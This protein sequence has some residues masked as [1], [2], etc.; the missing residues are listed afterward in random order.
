[1]KN[2][3]QLIRAEGHHVRQRIC[4]TK[5]QTLTT[6]AGSGLGLAAIILARSK[7]CLGPG[8]TASCEYRA[9]RVPA[10]RLVTTPSK[11]K[12]EVDF[13][14]RQFLDMLWPE[15]WYLLGAVV[16]AFGV[17]LVN[18]QIPLLLGDVVNVVSSLT[19]SVAQ[20]DFMQQIREPAVK[21]VSLYA[22]QSG[23]TLAYIWLLSSAGEHV[24]TRMRQLL[25]ERIITQDIAFFDQH[26]TGE[27]VNRLTSDVQD[28]KSSFKLCISQGLRALTQ[29]IGCAVSLYLVSPKLTGLLLVVVPSI[30]G[31]G[32]LLGSVLRIMSRKAQAQ[33]SRATGVA[34]EAIGNVRTVRAFAMENKE[35][36][37]YDTEVEEAA[38]LN[39]Q[40]GFGIGVFQALSN[41]ALNGVVLGTLYAGG[42]LVSTSE[43]SAGNLMSFTVATQ[44]VQRSLSQLSLLFGQAVRGT[45]AGARVFEYINLSREMPID[46]GKKIPYHSIMGSVTFSK[47]SFSY[48]TRPDQ[49]VL[50]DF[51]LHIPGGKV[52]AL[53]GLSGGGKST[54]ASLLERFYDVHGGSVRIDDEDI[55]NLNPSW[56]RGNLIGYINQEPTL[57]ASSVMENIRYGN[58]EATDTEVM[59]AAKMANAHGFISGFPDGYATMLGERGVTVSGGQKQRIAIARALI[60]NPT[61]LV[62]DEATSALDAESERVVQEALDKASKGRTVLVIAH[63]LSTIK[64]AD[65]I[66]VV[67]NGAIAE[68]GTHDELKKKQGLY[69]ELI[70]QQETKR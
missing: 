26:R 25:F 42:Y 52:V 43:L 53:C 64:D 44:T 33:V 22:I 21:L 10:S 19:S 59:E 12:E 65:I 58:P 13:P 48:P 16:S 32:A 27:I 63:R 35:M 30:I 17:A 14:W 28:F 2:C 40:L 55:R 8:F 54:V 41:F 66:A 24:A 51:S 39:K 50:T 20:A 47:V 36:H 49:Q 60:K 29:T 6:C 4:Q 23:L 38:R 18:I 69:W 56:L 68:M 31:V 1:M 11:D 3:R 57:F 15:I 9:G 7:G 37:M 5:Q 34:D 62:L 46:G 45:S 67:A 70:R 61:I